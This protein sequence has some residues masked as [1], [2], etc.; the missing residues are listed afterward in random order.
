[1]FS[2]CVPTNLIILLP[3]VYLIYK[4]FTSVF[5]FEE[6]ESKNYYVDRGWVLSLIAIT[7]MHLVDIQYYDARIS[8]LG[9][10]LLAGVKN[11]ITKD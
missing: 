4:S 5:I 1:M 2:Y 9:W 7:G 6:E 11:I 3:I 8:I 10:V